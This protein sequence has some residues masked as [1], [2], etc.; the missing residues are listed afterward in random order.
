MISRTDPVILDPVILVNFRQEIQ[1]ISCLFLVCF[2]K[3]LY[4]C[5]E[6]IKYGPVSISEDVHFGGNFA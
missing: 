6:K 1:K 4:I 5:S 3:I 2:K